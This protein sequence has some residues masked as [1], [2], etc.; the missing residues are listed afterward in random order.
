MKKTLTLIV[1]LGLAGLCR[2]DRIK[3]KDGM[4]LGGPRVEVLS[5]DG[6]HVKVKVQ[7]GTVTLNAGRIEW[8]KIEFKA[9]IDSLVEN[10]TD[11][12]KNLF[13]LGVLCDQNQMVRE[14][15]EAYV[16]AL[17]KDGAA[18]EMLR[19]LAGIFEQRRMW[20]EAKEAYDRLLITNPADEALQKKAAFCMEMAKD[21]PAFN[22]KAGGKD[23]EPDEDPAQNNVEKD[24]GDK[25]DGPPAIVVDP[26]VK[27]DIKPDE[28]V[29]DPKPPENRD[30]L[31][32]NS[33][34][35]VEQWGNSATCEIV[36]QGDDNKILSIAWAR[37]DK[38]KVAVGLN[39]D[40]D[41]KDKTK[42]TFDVYNDATAA[43]GVSVAFN[44][45]PGYQFFESVS[46]NSAPKKWVPIE[47]NLAAK[48]FKCA[49]TNWRYKAEIANRDNVKDLF[50]LIYNRD[51]AGVVFIDNIRFQTAGEDE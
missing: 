12:P 13:D 2:A 16:L 20:P 35:R 1:A 10:G 51:A 25:N 42:L 30:S 39:V 3:F 5:R 23:P 45:L 27:P 4:E 11:T 40:M 46:F 44:T 26:E 22:V 9:R 36:V 47:I 14:A 18:E 41:L 32:A 34:W 38:E 43:A 6:E 24:P 29:E 31:E 19:Q 50:I 15:T 7:Y 49:A 37:K 8:I 33:L 48:R 28:K 17:H 21:A